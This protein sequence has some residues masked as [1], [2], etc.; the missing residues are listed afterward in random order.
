MIKLVQSAKFY[1]L[2]SLYCESTTV[3]LVIYAMI[4]LFQ[5]AKFDLLASLY[6]ESTAINSVIFAI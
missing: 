1:L 6:C 2:S 4:K 3:N 5:S